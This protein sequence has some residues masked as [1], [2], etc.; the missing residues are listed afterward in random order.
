MTQDKLIQAISICDKMMPKETIGVQQEKI[1]HKIIKYLLTTNEEEHEIKIG[2]MY[3]DVMIDNN[4]YEIQT[5]NFN[6]LRHKLDVLLDNY[7]VTIIYPTSRVKEIYLL[8]EYGELIKKSKSPKKGTPFQLLVEQYKITSYLNHPNLHFKV[9]FFDMDE[10]RTEVPKKHYKSQGYERLKQVPSELIKIYDL[11][12]YD[13]YYE[14]FKEYNF[15]S[16]FT[17]MEFSKKFKMSYNKASSAI[18]SL[19]T[20]GII[21][22][23]KKDG[24]KNVWT[25]KNKKI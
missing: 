6:A 5:R 2:R 9:L 24:K 18:R 20:L 22:V 7:N 10:Y 3:V 21:E 13:D 11:N 17:V 16:D 15:T 8:N 19:S 23:A 12:T 25:L 4:I 14:V 1:L